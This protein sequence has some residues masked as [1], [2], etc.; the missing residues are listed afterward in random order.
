M[1]TIAEAREA[2]KGM[3]GVSATEPFTLQFEGIH[4]FGGSI[5]TVT[6]QWDDDDESADRVRVWR[7]DAGVLKVEDTNL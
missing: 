1:I 3:Y 4:P 7:D 5:F 2:I 6:V